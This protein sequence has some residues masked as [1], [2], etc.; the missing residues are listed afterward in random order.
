V[1]ITSTVSSLLQTTVRVY[2]VST[3]FPEQ[4]FAVWPFWWGHFCTQITDYI[5][6]L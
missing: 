2:T 4:D 3:I 1:V 5:S 6:L